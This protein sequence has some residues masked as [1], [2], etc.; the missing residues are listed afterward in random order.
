MGD[1]GKWRTVD[2]ERHG[3][4]GSVPLPPGLVMRYVFPRVYRSGYR[5]SFWRLKLYCW[6]PVNPLKTARNLPVILLSPIK[7]KKS[8]TM[9]TLPGNTIKSRSQATAD[10]A[11]EALQS[12]QCYDCTG[13]AV[14]DA[15]RDLVSGRIQPGARRNLSKTTPRD[16]KRWRGAFAKKT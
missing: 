16:G 2:N 14:H 10:R 3:S 12:L 13:N 11:M 7:S 1:V 4:T 8:G 5:V 6:I 9:L 15:R